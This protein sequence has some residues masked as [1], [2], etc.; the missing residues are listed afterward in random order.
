MSENGKPEIVNC[1]FAFRCSKNW[2]E[3]QETD[4]TNVRFC[5]ECKKNVYF[6]ENNAALK[7]LSVEGKCVAVYENKP[8][9]NFPMRTTG[10]PLPPTGDIIDSGQPKWPM[11]WQMT[12]GLPV[13][14]NHPQKIC[15]GK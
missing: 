1:D 14:Y 13:L 12:A 15:R 4:R 6:A 9:S 8:V 2:T 11:P 3:M 7:R 5:G 10:M